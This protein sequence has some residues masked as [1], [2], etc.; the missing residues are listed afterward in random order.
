MLSSCPNIK[1]CQEIKDSEK[2]FQGNIDDRY[3]S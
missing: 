3:S 2:Q 1:Q